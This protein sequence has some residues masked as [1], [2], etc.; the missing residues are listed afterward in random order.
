MT[1][2]TIVCPL[3][4]SWVTSIHFTTLYYISDTHFNIILPSIPCFSKWP[5]SS[6][7]YMP[8]VPST[9]P[10][11]TFHWYSRCRWE[12]NIE[13]KQHTYNIILR[14]FSVT[15]VAVKQ[16]LVLYILR[17]CLQPYLSKT[18]STCAILYWLLPYLP[19]SCEW[20]KRKKLLN[21]KCVFWFS[22]QL[23]Y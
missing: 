22:H 9:L 3:T 2:F 20:H 8:H 17:V 11:L 16:Q 6:H 1:M 4:L 7:P 14:C 18:Q 23:L 13:G 5:R 21:T 10:S 19:T 15:T 12:D